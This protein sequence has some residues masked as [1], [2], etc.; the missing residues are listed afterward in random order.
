MG[1]TYTPNV[2]FRRVVADGAWP[3][4]D[5]FVNAAIAS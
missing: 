4:V 3:M 1:D 5:L 2:G